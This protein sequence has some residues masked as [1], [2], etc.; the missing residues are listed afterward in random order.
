MISNK[1]L[2]TYD[3]ITCNTQLYHNK[4][5]ILEAVI[6]YRSVSL[7][8]RGKWNKSTSFYLKKKSLVN[9]KLLPLANSSTFFLD[10]TFIQIKQLKFVWCLTCIEIITSR[11]SLH[12]LKYGNIKFCTFYNRNVYYFQTFLRN[13][14]YVKPR[15]ICYFVAGET[16]PV[17]RLRLRRNV[18]IISFLDPSRSR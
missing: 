10:M 5:L 4:Q 6:V 9:F 7:H 12:D 1:C 14:S 16:R 3:Y 15:G 18:D 2:L 17:H 13:A 8:I 11:T